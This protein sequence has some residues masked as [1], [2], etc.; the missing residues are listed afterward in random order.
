[1]AVHAWTCACIFDLACVSSK[2]VAGIKRIYEIVIVDITSE[3]TT[4]RKPSNEHLLVYLPIFGIRDR[5]A[6]TYVR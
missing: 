3:T 5:C 2:C 4:R 6:T 1:M